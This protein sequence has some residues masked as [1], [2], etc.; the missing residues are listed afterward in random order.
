MSHFSYPAEAHA[1]PVLCVVCCPTCG[2]YRCPAAVTEPAQNA[3]FCIIT[4]QWEEC[5]KH[6]SLMAGNQ[7][8]LSLCTTVLRALRHPN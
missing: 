5:R 7:S 1:A 8:V 4:K 3:P 2:L 6:M